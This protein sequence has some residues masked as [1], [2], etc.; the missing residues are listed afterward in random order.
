MKKKKT[1]AKKPAK[2]QKLVC[3]ECGLVV[4]VDT[5]CGCAGGCDVLCCGEQMKTKK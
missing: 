3:K 4:S 5:E 2:K 1:V